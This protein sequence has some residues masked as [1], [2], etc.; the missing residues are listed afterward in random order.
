MRPH[1]RWRMPSITGRVTLKQALR[2]VFTTSVH[3]S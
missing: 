3:C 1:L 2:L